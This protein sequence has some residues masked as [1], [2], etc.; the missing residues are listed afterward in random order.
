MV[1][2]GFSI[3][4]VIKVKYLDVCHLAECYSISRYYGSISIFLRAY[5]EEFEPSFMQIG[6]TNPIKSE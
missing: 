2:I 5:M 3:Y 4:E 1:N 6:S